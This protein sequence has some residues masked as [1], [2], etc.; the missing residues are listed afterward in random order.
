MIPPLALPIVRR[1]ILDL[2]EEIGGEHNHDTLTLQLR[3]LG[4]RV[5]ARDVAEQ[6]LWLGGAGLVHAEAL[7]PYTVARVLADGRDVATGQLTVEGVS[8]HRTGD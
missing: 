2:L 1:A 8:R 3:S 7:G 5:A 4:H 6:L